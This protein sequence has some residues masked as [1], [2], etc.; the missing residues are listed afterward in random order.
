MKKIGIIGL[1][2]ATLLACSREALPEGAFLY[3][4]DMM[5]GKMAMSGESGVGSDAGP[6]P[7]NG[8]G[9]GQS[10]AGRLTAGEWND[11]ENWDFWGK[12]MTS[13]D[14]GGQSAYWGFYTNNRIAVRVVDTADQPVAGAKVALAR[15]GKAIWQA[16]T[17]NAGYADL[18]VSLYQKEEAD[19]ASLTVSVNGKEQEGAPR[20]TDWTAGQGPVMNKYTVTATAAPAAVD[21]A[22]IVDATGS[23]TDEI[24]FL[25]DDLMDILTK[26]QKAQTDVKYRTAALF[27]R[28]EGDDYLTRPSNFNKD[29]SVTHSFISKQSAGGGGDYPE[30]VHTALEQGLQALS[31]SESARNRLAFLILDAPAHYRPEVV[32]SLH[33]SI[34]KYAS[35][36]IRI[37]PVAASGVD[38]S[39]EFMCRFFAVSTGGTYVFLTDHSGIGESHIAPT[40]GSYEVELLNDLLLRLIG[41]YSN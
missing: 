35:L 17:D 30:A 23:M 26:A 19:A 7:G 33:A 25:K 24:K 21:I 29:F 41:E 3:D 32:E 28:D 36:G 22:F 27:Y 2:L 15:G 6:E 18:F 31:W 5:D 13:E 10:E 4:G 16:V 1:A 39:T 34:E 38:K 11:L 20:L 12:L 9:N 14:H 8:D 40:V 37:I